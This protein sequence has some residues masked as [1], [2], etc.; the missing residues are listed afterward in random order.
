MARETAP[1]PPRFVEVLRSLSQARTRADVRLTE[2]PPPSRIAPFAVAV[3][4]E[5]AAEGAEATGR[6]VVLHDPEGQDAWDGDLR[7]VALVKATVEQ[8]VG[9]DDLWAEVAWSWLTESLAEVP[10]RE[11]GGTVTKVVSTSFGDLASRPDEVNVEL[12]V[13]WT[14]EDTDLEPHIAAWTD[15]LATC[16]GVP[17]VPDGVSVLPGASR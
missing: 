16:A 2:T 3:D 12:R 10:H 8:E 14:P 13:S 7:I 1:A 17:P 11:V 6:F 4:G 15:L 5:V 9:R